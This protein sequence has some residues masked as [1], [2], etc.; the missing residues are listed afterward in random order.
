MPLGSF[1]QAAW[2]EVVGWGLLQ[3]RLLSVLAGVLGILIWFDLVRLWSRDAL[4]AGF[5]AMLI[6][7][8]WNYLKAAYVGRMDMLGCLF[9]LSALYAHE[10]FFAQRPLLARALSAAALCAAAM[11]HPLAFAVWA[12]VYA[13][14][15]LLQWRQITLTQTAAFAVPVIVT[16]VLFA[17]WI[18]F[19]PNAFHDQMSAQSGFRVASVSF[20]ETTRYLAMYG[21]Q[22][23]LFSGALIRSL[24]AFTFLGAVVFLWVKRREMAGL[25]GLRL[26]LLLGGVAFLALTLADK[27][28]WGQYGIHTA[29]W[30]G[31]IAAYAIRT[32]W[33]SRARVAVAAWLCLYLLAPALTGAY[34]VRN[35]S[36]ERIYRPAVAALDRLT[37]DRGTAFAPPE[38]I[39]AY[40]RPFLYDARLGF[41]SGRS[42]PAMALYK[43]DIQSVLVWSRQGNPRLYAHLQSM[44]RETCTLRYENEKYAVYSCE[45][46]ARTP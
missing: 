13:V 11:L 6:A 2:Y 26:A 31:V 35:D 7:F 5:S 3:Q 19:D 42:V 43:Q 15:C 18:G 46:P 27:M 34:V 16:A 24:P 41:L 21:F 1:L 12:A 22:P 33:R 14:R 25:P 40:R 23:H 39:F 4:L 36:Y 20:D 32:L 9:G 44:L 28:K 38:F 37:G 17:L 29:P 10:R 45:K 30:M 8:D